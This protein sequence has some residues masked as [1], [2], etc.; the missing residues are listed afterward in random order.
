MPGKSYPYACEQPYKQH[1]LLVLP[2]IACPRCQLFQDLCHR[3]SLCGSV[4]GASEPGTTS[5]RRAASAGSLPSAYLGHAP[6]A[7]ARIYEAA[8]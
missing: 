7:D 6:A 1:S 2:R 3:Q 4:T 8:P 5:F